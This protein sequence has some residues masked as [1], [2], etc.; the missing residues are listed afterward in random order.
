MNEKPTVVVYVDSEDRVQ[1][2]ST[3]LSAVDVVVVYPSGV[4]YDHIDRTPVC[5]DNGGTREEF[6]KWKN[7]IRDTYASEK[8]RNN[9]N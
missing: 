5:V 6:T 9:G 4:I 3:D 7:L 8:H 2:I 1:K